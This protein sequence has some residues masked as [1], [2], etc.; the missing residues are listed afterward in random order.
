MQPFDI[1]CAVMKFMV[2]SALSIWDCNVCTQAATKSASFQTI[3]TVF[4]LIHA[5]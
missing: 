5:P 2:A 3:Q 4:P 1:N